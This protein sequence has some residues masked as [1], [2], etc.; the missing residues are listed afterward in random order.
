VEVLWYNV[1]VGNEQRRK[2]QIK[3]YVVLAH[4]EIFIYEEETFYGSRL[5]GCDHSIYIPDR[6]RT[7]G[8]RTSAEAI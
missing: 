2:R 8:A 7:E 1:Q 3:S 4:K 5:S 6:M